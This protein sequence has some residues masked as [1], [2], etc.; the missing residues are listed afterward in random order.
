MK[1]W[2]PS[3]LVL[4]TTCASPALGQV[5]PTLPRESSQQESEADKCFFEGK[6]K[7]REQKW[8]EAMLLFECSWRLK[9][10]YDSAGNLG[11]VAL[12]LGMYTKAATHLDRC[13][14][15][16]PATGRKTQRAQIER[17]FREASTH[18]A[19]VHFTTPDQNGELVLDRTVELGATRAP[20]GAVF[21]NPGTHIVQLR[22][23]DQI[24]AEQAFLAV[25]GASQQVQIGIA[26]E[27]T[28][29][30]GFEMASGTTASQ[31]KALP[32]PFAHDD[33]NPHARS[34]VPIFVGAGVSVGSF[35]VAGVL[36][37]SA[38]NHL[39]DARSLQSTL[40]V[41]PGDVE[42]RTPGNAEACQHLRRELQSSDKRFNW[43]Y[44]MFGL[45][46]AS[47][48]ATVTYTFW[49]AL[50]GGPKGHAQNRALPIDVR[51]GADTATITLHAQF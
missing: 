46:G 31:V 27:R 43:S 51:A 40:N 8:D 10:S 4:S 5:S 38:N 30:P 20:L 23:G 41:G 12:K 45:G 37:N 22:H 36:L 21:V 1:L 44:A 18:V 39:N 19:I 17:L 42:C 16:F 13:L 9:P 34:A 3:I 48:L 47:L 28:G 7:A 35:V 25:A 26:T 11:Q 29:K 49:P 2:L 24:T 50:M 33:S 14:H 32:Q 15:M 6:A